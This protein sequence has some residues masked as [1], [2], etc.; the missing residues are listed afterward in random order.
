MNLTKA[1][2]DRLRNLKNIYYAEKCDYSP[3]YSCVYGVRS[4]PTGDV[5]FLRARP[6]IDHRQ[7]RGEEMFP[8]RPEILDRDPQ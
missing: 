1:V 6:R 2:V 4:R 5:E 8:M 7:G 3:P